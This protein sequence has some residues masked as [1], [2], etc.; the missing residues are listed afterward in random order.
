VRLDVLPRGDRA[1]VLATHELL[2]GLWLCVS[3]A[4]LVHGDFEA[5]VQVRRPHEALLLLGTL[6]LHL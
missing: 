2:D 5:M 3:D 1:I 6:H 4:E